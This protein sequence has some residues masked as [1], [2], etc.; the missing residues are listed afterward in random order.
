MGSVDSWSEVGGRVREARLAHGLS[1]TELARKLGLDRTAVV[2]IESGQRQVSAMEL[3]KLSDVLGVPPTHFVTRPPAAVISQRQ[4]LAEGADAASRTRFRLDAALEA[5]ARDTGWLVEHGLLA[6]AAPASAPKVRNKKEARRLASEIRDRAGLSSDPISGMAELAERFGL[7]ILVLDQDVEGAS[8]L[9]D[10]YGVAVLGGRREP[11]RRRFTAAHELGHHLLQDEYHTDIGVAASAQER[12]AVIDAFAAELL[13]PSSAL[14]RLSGRGDLREELIRLAGTY[15]VSWSVIVSGAERA[16][17][18]PDEQ[19][20][21]LRAETPVKGEFLAVLGE[22]PKADLEVGHTGPAWR[23]AVLAAWERSLI[24]AA[25][26][27]ELLR[28]EITEDELPPR[29]SQR[30]AE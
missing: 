25:R 22:E 7:Y 4:T 3:F 29:S 2:R 20:P 19:L 8:L 12:E 30:D 14:E 26:T 1:Q 16:E 11:G 6:K 18:I 10:G 15:R 9:L 21:R 27:V 23:R 13:L 17:L 24:T 5:H 28:Q